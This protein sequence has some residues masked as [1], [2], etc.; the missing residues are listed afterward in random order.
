[1]QTDDS[2][3]MGKSWSLPR[4]RGP[5]GWPEILAA[6]LRK[7]GLMIPIT[8]IAAAAEAAA[9]QDTN[10]SRWVKIKRKEAAEIEWDQECPLTSLY[11][12]DEPQQWR[13]L[14]EIKNKS[15]RGHFT[16]SLQVAK[17]KIDAVSKMREDVGGDESR[18]WEKKICRTTMHIKHKQDFIIKTNIHY[19]KDKIKERKKLKQSLKSQQYHLPPKPKNKNTPLLSSLSYVISPPYT[20]PKE[21]ALSVRKLGSKNKIPCRKSKNMTWVF[22]AFLG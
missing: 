16:T 9:A 5:S 12:T 3:N 4:K 21:E 15:R 13:G 17:I 20:S 14:A 7:K 22:G 11:I 1:M 8:I 19:H 2:S 6:V 10:Q 18:S